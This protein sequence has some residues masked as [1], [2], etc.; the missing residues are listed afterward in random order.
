M[1]QVS[2][3][4]HAVT[5]GSAAQGLPLAPPRPVRFEIADLGH[6]GRFEAEL[7]EYPILRG[8]NCIRLVTRAR[9]RSAI[10]HLAPI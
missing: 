2:P 10:N 8:Y 6:S 1:G 4:L 9:R 5:D 7:D 3:S